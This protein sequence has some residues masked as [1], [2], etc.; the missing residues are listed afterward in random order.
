MNQSIKTSSVI[1]IC[2]S[3]LTLALLWGLTGNDFIN[4][5]DNMY[6]TGNQHVLSGFTKEN[7]A[8][9]FIADYAANWH[10]LT[11]LSHMADVELFGV[12]P[13]WH[14]LVNLLF[15][16][17]NVCL[18]FIAFN[19]LTGMFPQS[20]LAALIFAVH[21]LH[22]ESVAWVA[23]RK[24]LLSTF[25]GLLSLLAY[26]QYVRSGRKTNYATLLVC[27]MLSL[28]SKPMLVTLPFVLLLLDY[29]PLRRFEN[30]RSKISQFAKLVKDKMPLFALSVASSCITLYVQRDAMSTLETVSISNRLSNALN[31]YVIY[32]AKAI[33]P[34][35][36]AVIYPLPTI[37]PPI[38]TICSVVVLLAVTTVGLLFASK[39][40]Y[41]IV[42]WFWFLGTLV[43]TIGIVQVGLQSMADRYMYFPLIGICIL[44]IYWLSDLIAQWPLL[45]K[46]IITVAS[47]L[48]LFYCYVTWNYVRVWQNSTKLFTHALSVTTN[49]YYAHYMLGCELYQKKMV[50][51][52]IA[53]YMES[54]RINPR[55]TES[56]INLGIIYAER[57]N[58]V[59]AINSFTNALFLKPSSVEGHYN[60][61]CAL[62]T[63]GRIEEAVFH[64]QET[65]KLAPFHVESHNNLGL[66]MMRLGRYDEAMA[67]FNEALRQAPNYTESR[68]NLEICTQKKMS[69]IQRDGN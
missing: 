49:N 26:T 54:I 5:D 50:N 4:Y 10:P 11:W 14:H 67:Y 43:P 7:V 40:P 42:G 8:W 66:I 46:P 47:A 57:G 36:L 3:L 69:Q 30:S 32:F 38:Q 44:V 65:I 56:H 25:F 20:A 16:C 29:W 55:S 63:Q 6:I 62:Q 37:I 2:L 21:P 58:L 60:I 1:C 51:D 68:L 18:V 59:E 61:A 27:F 35:D 24:D 64:Y 12:N 41:L 45:R 53:H 28:M 15:H 33:W 19:R 22:V 9:A 34:Y 48:V 31:S 39:K 17:A 23:E 13:Q 52:S